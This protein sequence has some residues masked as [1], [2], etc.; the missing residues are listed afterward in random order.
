MHAARERGESRTDVARLRAGVSCVWD[1][2]DEDDRPLTR[3]EMQ[4][5]VKVNRKQRNLSGG[6][7]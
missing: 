7:I 2:R 4:T 1:G 6:H 3:E 5:G